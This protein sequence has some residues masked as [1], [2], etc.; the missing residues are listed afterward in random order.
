MDQETSQMYRTKLEA[1]R[2]AE[3]E[4]AESIREGL[5]NPQQ[6]S[7]GELSLYD[8]HPGDVGDSTFERGKDLGLKMLTEQ[9]LAMIEEALEAIEKGTYGICQVC[10]R[11]ID[12]DRLEAIPFTR[13]CQE[14][15]KNLE[16]LERHSRPIE[17]EVIL[18]PFGGLDIHKT[19]LEDS[20]DNNAFDGEDAWQAVARYGT[21]N[22]PSDIG[23]VEDY[24]EVYVNAGEDI[25]SVEDYEDIAGHKKKDGQFYQS[26]QG[27]DDEGSPYNHANE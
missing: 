9:R 14:C 17:E 22:S 11:E 16:E 8:N 26:F 4:A 6:N 10:G 13:Q 25:G 3:M 15:R 5:R 23:S 2:Q 7:V 27:E 19:Y 18:P 24:N 21:S 1:L 20:V 12:M